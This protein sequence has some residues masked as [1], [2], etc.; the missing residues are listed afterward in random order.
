MSQPHKCVCKTCQR[1][2]DE[3]YGAM[4]EMLNIYQGALHKEIEWEKARETAAD[5]FDWGQVVCN[6]GPPCFHLEENGRFCG[7]SGRWAGHENAVDHA[8]VPLSAI[9]SAPSCADQT[10]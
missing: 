2:M 5:N 1:P 6:E 3:P 7:R 8:F 4:K 9:V 10:T